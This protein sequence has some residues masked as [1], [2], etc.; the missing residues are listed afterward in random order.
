MSVIEWKGLKIETKSQKLF[1]LNESTLGLNWNQFGLKNFHEIENSGIELYF[2][3]L[4][5]KPTMN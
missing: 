3:E 5:I 2:T 4:S 1:R